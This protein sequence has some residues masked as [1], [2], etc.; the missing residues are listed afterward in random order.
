MWIVIRRN[1]EIR[2]LTKWTQPRTHLQ[3][4]HTHH[5]NNHAFENMVYFRYVVISLSDG[6]RQPAPWWA[7]AILM[8][9]CAVSL[10]VV[11]RC[12][13]LSAIGTRTTY[14]CTHAHTHTHTH[15]I[16]HARICTCT[17]A[18]V[19]THPHTHTHTHRY[20]HTHTH[21]Y[22]RTRKPI[23]WSSCAC[24]VSGYDCNIRGLSNAEQKCGVCM[25]SPGLQS[26][27][28]QSRWGDCVYLSRVCLYV[29][30]SVAVCSFYLG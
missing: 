2:R 30:V 17:R 14:T 23:S 9:S 21:T 5:E 16:T 20:T 7:W 27:G 13:Q 24:Q 10:G 3:S 26:P 28:L 25:C 6:S 15:H 19:H 11:F 8:P 12:A 4:E 18:R 1:S 29:C 22:T